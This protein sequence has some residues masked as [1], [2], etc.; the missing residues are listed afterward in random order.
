MNSWKMSTIAKKYK[1]YCSTC[2]KHLQHTHQY[3]Q[4]KFS[5]ETLNKAIDYLNRCLSLL[6]RGVYLSMYEQ[7]LNEVTTAHDIQLYI[8][9]EQGSEARIRQAIE[10]LFDVL[11]E[12]SQGSDVQ[13]LS[14][15][16]TAFLRRSFITFAR[17]LQKLNPSEDTNK[18]LQKMLSQMSE[19]F[20]W[21]SILFNFDGCV[22]QIVRGDWLNTAL[23]EMTAGVKD[24]SQ[25][26]HLFARIPWAS[27]DKYSE[28]ELRG[29]VL[30][31]LERF[32][33][34]ALERGFAKLAVMCAE[35]AV[36]A[37]NVYPEMSKKV[38]SMLTDASLPN[39]KIVMSSVFPF[40]PFDSLPYKNL[41][42]IYS[43]MYF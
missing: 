1:F 37:C 23:E 13:T 2:E 27:I 11:R 17:L 6:T 39:S 20:S 25:F 40:L 38:V 31:S 34:R 16:T 28:S 30:G 42:S 19:G 10:T 7:T 21:G 33:R 22:D 12:S 8:T 5:V 26:L 15:S 29:F 4:A 18:Y 32:L 36:F 35:V 43:K 9:A 24:E 14:A 41:C 3:K